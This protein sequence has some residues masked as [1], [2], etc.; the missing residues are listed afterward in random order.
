MSG[1]STYLNTSVINI[2]R[3]DVARLPRNMTV[4]QTLDEIRQKGLGERIV[5]FYVVD[6]DDRLVGVVPTRRL[7]SAPTEQRISEIMITPPIMIPQHTTVFEAH[8]Y[9][10]RHKFLAFPVTDE[11]GRILGVV[12]IA[13]FTGD[14]FDVADREDMNRVFET[15]GFRIMQVREASP[16]R[17]FRL[18]F[19]WLLATITSGT[20]CAL[21]VG[22]Y[23]VTLAKSL[24]LAFFLTLV[25][26]LGESVSIQSMTLAIHSLRSRQPDW[27]WYIRAFY[28]EVSAAML[29]GVAC[30]LVVGLIAWLWRNEGMAAL[31]IGASIMLTLCGGVFWGLTI[32]S[33]LHKLKLDMRIAAGPIT[34]ALTDISTIL[35]YFSIAKALL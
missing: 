28:R 14:N 21:L 10:M 9:F 29:L 33:L 3:K 7:L 12:D 34:L 27:L 19:P 16:L 20:V 31:T 4:Q 32:P 26:G 30:G 24:I 35:I 2:A 6:E 15:I 11:Q 1:D 18:R 13:M 22:V 8:E 25:L 5:Y 17:A 23:E